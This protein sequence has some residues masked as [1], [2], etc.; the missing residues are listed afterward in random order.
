MSR[1]SENSTFICAHCRITVVPLTN[2][3]YRNH[4]PHCLYSLHVDNVPGDR[5]SNCGG[6][7]Q[8]V[9]LIYHSKKGYQIR[10]RC[11]KCGAERVNR[12]AENTL[13]PDDLDV[14]LGLMR[15]N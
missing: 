1:K 2:G 9:G 4:C 8:P 10:H 11:I 13:Q 3:S 12:I 15:H 14:M 6:L 5:S 7:M